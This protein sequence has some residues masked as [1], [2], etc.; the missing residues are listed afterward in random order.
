MLKGPLKAALH[1]LFALCLLLP[2]CG[3][4]EEVPASTE[5]AKAVPTDPAPAPKKRVASAPSNGWG[6]DIAWQPLENGLEEAKAERMPTM[7]VV[8]TSW[9]GKCKALKKSAFADKTLKEL[10][11]EFV[12]VNVDQD[13]EPSARDYAPD[14]NYIPRIVFLDPDG[15]LDPELKNP[16]PSRFKYFYTP[17]DDL[18]ATM[19]K[20]LERHADKS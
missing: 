20:A 13:T 14:G 4:R 18:A 19:R 1:H 9:C 17:Q 15:K 8:H 6:E 7:L 5:T 16:R 3:A 12:M 11:E 10:S 2:A